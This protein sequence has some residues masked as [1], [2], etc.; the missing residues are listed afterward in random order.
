MEKNSKPTPGQGD[1]APQPTTTADN[2]ATT[3]PAPPAHVAAPVE[4]ADEGKAGIAKISEATGFTP[5]QVGIVKNQVA[6]GTTNTELAFFLMQAKSLGLNPFNKEIW[7]YKDHRGNMLIFTGRDGFLA[8]AQKDPRYNGI[9]SGCIREN[10][11]YAIDIPN[12]RI[13]HRIKGSLAA[14]GQIVGAYALVFM[15]DRST[16]VKMETGM[17]YVPWENYKKDSPGPWK[18]HPDE[19]LI[20]VAESHALKKSM[21]FSGLQVEEDFY[22]APDGTLRAHTMDVPD[23]VVVDHNLEAKATLVRLAL[24]NYN[25]PDH[26]AIQDECVRRRKD[27]SFTEAFADQVLARIKASKPSGSIEDVEAVPA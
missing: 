8:K 18:S 7:C 3:T 12:G 9:R 11:E 4:V 17:V 27:G 1:G 25:G 14:R 5:A 23:E 10:D 26:D 19:M 15:V 13:D 2:P 6:K 22:M 21:G 20:K 24:A 16:G